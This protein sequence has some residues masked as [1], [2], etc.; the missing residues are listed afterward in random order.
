MSPYSIIGLTMSRKSPIRT[1]GSRQ[2]PILGKRL[3]MKPISSTSNAP[4]RLPPPAM[5]FW[6]SDSASRWRA[7]PTSSPSR[8]R[9]PIGRRTFG[10]CRVRSVP[11]CPKAT[12][13]ARSRS[14]F[15]CPTR[16]SASRRGTIF[17]PI[18]CSIF[19]RR[20]VRSTRIS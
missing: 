20:L 11:I 12:T 16:H 13:S 7:T 15:P 18:P 17:Q 4:R 8:R 3:P 10:A 6:R 14:C 1:C 2:I 19:L 9:F 5:T